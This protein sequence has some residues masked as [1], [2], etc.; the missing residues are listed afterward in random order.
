MNDAKSLGAVLEPLYE[1]VLEP[2]RLKDFNR[3]IA[4]ATGSSIAAVVVHD[5]A[6]GKGDLSLVH[7]VDADM[8]SRRLAELDLNDDPWIARALPQLATGRMINSDDL[9]PRAQMHRTAAF[10]EYYRGLDIG[11]QVASVGYYDGSAS[12][13]LSICRGV[14]A[15]AFGK[16][17][18]SMLHALTP[19]WVNAYAVQR[20]LSWLQRRVDTLEAAIESVPMAMFLLDAQQ[21]VVRMSATAEQ[22][23]STG[24]VLRLARGKLRALF[25]AN[26]LDNLLHAACGRG[27]QDGRLMQSPGRA[28]LRDGFG[29]HALVASAHPL[30]GCLQQGR[31]EV[32]ALFLSTI[33]LPMARALNSMLRQVFGLTVAEAS[34]AEAL[35]RHADLAM[36]AECVGISPA[37]A[38]TRLKL[39]FDKTGEHGQPALMRLLAALASVGGTS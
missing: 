31:G 18:L 19:H 32:A 36:A 7:G 27:W 34:L 20:R 22:I 2:G 12:V 5:V 15:P 39:I 9:L 35:Y 1:S 6:N 21:R 13:T 4:S 37:S 24:N 30:A 23:L 26:A 10:N 25:D 11:Q 38:H 16:R 28:T 33:G 8:L 29:R 14:S 17:E 3:R